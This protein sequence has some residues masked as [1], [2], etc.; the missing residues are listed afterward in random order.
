[1][2]FFSGI[3]NFGSKI[4]IRIKNVT[5]WVAPALHKVLSTI[6]GPV[7][8][9]HPAIGGA[10]GAGAN[11]AVRQL[12]TN[13]IAYYIQYSKHGRSSGGMM[14]NE[15]A[16][17]GTVSVFEATWYDSGNIVHDQI[18]PASDEIQ[19]TDG[20]DSTGVGIAEV[21]MEYS[22]AHHNHQIKASTS[23]LQ[24]DASISNINLTAEKYIKAG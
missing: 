2:D 14:S 5:K 4:L 19:I 17:S 11:L 24:K 16:E 8:M 3:T 13:D 6:S 23:L 18:T 10:L 1:M 21:N 9:I 20:R 12:I 7:G 15:D 22:R